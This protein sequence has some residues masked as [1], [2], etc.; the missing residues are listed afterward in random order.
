MGLNFFGLWELRLPSGLTR[1]ASKNLGGALGSLFMGLTLG[2][3]AAPCVGPFIIGL[4]T[5]VGQRGDPLLG[6]LYFFVLSLGLGLPLGVLAVFSDQADRLPLSGEWMVWVRKGLGWVLVG[7]AVYVL[8]PLMPGRAWRVGLLSAVMAVA[9]LHLGW[10]DR[11]GLRHPRFVF[12][13]KAL[14]AA[15]LGGAIFLFS[16]SLG[17]REGVQWMRYEETIMDRA[18]SEG[19]PVLLD[20][21][22]DWCGPCRAMD[23]DVFTEKEVL[24]LS[25]RLVAVRVDLT[26][27]DPSHEALQRRYGVKGVPTIVFINRRGIEERDLRIESYVR[28]EVMAARMKRLLDGP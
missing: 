9:G 16:L 25:R 21:Y 22:A 24:A 4:L 3:V 8:W 12:L 13:R 20:F 5:Y 2:I 1:M 23:E 11:S 10:V 27:R 7:M 17:E 18:R 6:F 26:T 14:G 28:K 15:A 19:E